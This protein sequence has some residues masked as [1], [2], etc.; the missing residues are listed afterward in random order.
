MKVVVAGAS[1]VVGGRCA[2]IL[3]ERGHDLVLISRDP[4]R[5]AGLPGVP[6]QLDL[7]Q[8]IDGTAT[9]LP[10]ADVLVN[11]AGPSVRWTHPVALAALRAGMDF[12]DPGG[13]LEEV[14]RLATVAESEGHTAV[15]GA[16]VQPGLVAIAVQAVVLRT[17]ACRVRGSCGGLQT[18]SISS[19]E[20]YVAAAG[21]SQE[22]A[23]RRLHE[24]RVERAAPSKAG[25]L[26]GRYPP[27]ATRHLH[28]DQEVL[29]VAERLGCTDLTWFNVMDAPRSSAA[30][31]RLLAG[32]GSES[33]ALAA[34]AEDL[35][36]REPYFR[37]EVEAWNGDECTRLGIA[38]ADCYDLTARILVQ[39]AELAVAGTPGALFASGI[40]VSPETWLTGLLGAAEIT[41][42]EEGEL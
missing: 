9:V 33:D 32:G 24:G 16:G 4:A 19:V 6:L 10:E 3:A 15:L 21:T 7:G 40:G 38:T 41:W 27:S 42:D 17:G 28:L 39:A 12:T 20:D 8:L 31:A 36:N 30:L 34:V 29:G 35:R 26:P 23:G 14:H 18:L 13:D 5:I 1:G 25:P 11:C 37:I 2:T 22:A